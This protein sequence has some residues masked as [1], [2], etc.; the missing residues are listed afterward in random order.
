MTAVAAVEQPVL[1]VDAVS[2]EGVKRAELRYVEEAPVALG[3]E[4]GPRLVL[5]GRKRGKHFEAAVSASA[6][7]DAVYQMRRYGWTVAVDEA[8]RS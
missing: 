7:G 4:P 2:D 6:V 3:S 1:T 5:F 8:R